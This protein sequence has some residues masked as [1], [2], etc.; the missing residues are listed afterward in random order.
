MNKILK[1]FLVVVVVASIVILSTKFIVKQGSESVILRLGELKKDSSGQVIEYEPGIHI[2]VPL[3]DTVKTYDMRNRILE[4]DS[5][6]VVT[7]EQKDVLINAYVVWKIDN[8]SKF[9][10]STSGNVDRAE[11]LLKQFLESSLRAEVGNNDI[12]SLINNNRDKLMIALTKS[13][14][15]QAIQIGVSVVDVRVKQIDLPDTVTDSIYQRMKSSRHKVASSIRAEGVQLAEKIKAS[16]D[17]KV[18]VTIAQAEKESKTI[19]AEADGKAAKIF[20]AAYANSIPLY[21][22]LKSMNSYKESF[23]G[24]NEVVFMLKP[25]SKFFQGFKLQSNSKLA[26]DMKEAK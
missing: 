4:A 19:R 15:K 23:N 6:R 11:T 9:F 26:K 1:I 25:D 24:K 22:F 3:L 17:A 10:T 16:A 20:T 13:V 18:T 7:K 14:Q 8:I 12:Q 5:A 2:K 21:E